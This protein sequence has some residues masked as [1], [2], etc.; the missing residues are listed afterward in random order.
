MS[1]APALLI[2]NGRVTQERFPRY[3][4]RLLPQ[5]VDYPTTVSEGYA[6]AIIEAYAQ[7]HG[8]ENEARIDGEAARSRAFDPYNPSILLHEER[9]ETRNLAG[10]LL[11]RRRV[12]SRGRGVGFL[13]RNTGDSNTRHI[14][15]S[16]PE[17]GLEKMFSEFRDDREMQFAQIFRPIIINRNHW[18]MCEI[19]L[20]RQ[21]NGRIKVN[22]H[23]YDPLYQAAVDVENDRMVVACANRVFV[24]GLFDL[25][26]RSIVHRSKKQNDGTS[27]A[28]VSC[29]YVGQRLAG[30]GLE[31]SIERDIGADEVPF[32][33]SA[34][35]LRLHQ[36]R[37][38]QQHPQRVLD[39]YLNDAA[40]H[41]FK[42]HTRPIDEAK[43]TEVDRRPVLSLDELGVQ[44]TSP[45]LYVGAGI[46]AEPKKGL[47][48]SSG[49]SGRTPA[50][51][52]P[53]IDR[54]MSFSYDES[55]RESDTAAFLRE[56]F[57]LENF[58]SALT[59]K[60]LGLLVGIIR[61]YLTEQQKCGFLEPSDAD[62]LERVAV[63]VVQFCN[64]VS[65]S[66]NDYI[67]A[68]IKSRDDFLRRQA[69]LVLALKAL[70][71]DKRYLGTPNLGSEL[72]KFEAEH[73]V[74]SMQCAQEN[75]QNLDHVFI[76]YEL[77]ERGSWIQ[78][79]WGY[80]QSFDQTKLTAMSSTSG[81]QEDESVE[82]GQT[83]ESR[84]MSLG[85]ELRENNDLYENWQSFHH[86][87]ETNLG[88][89]LAAKSTELETLPK[90]DR[91]LV[92]KN[93]Y[94]FI[95]AI[96]DENER[97]KREEERE[98]RA[99][100]KIRIAQEM[101][102]L[103]AIAAAKESS[104]GL[105]ALPFSAAT[106]QKDKGLYTKTNDSEFAQR[107]K[108]EPQ[109]PYTSVSS[110]YVVSATLY[111]AQKDEFEKTIWANNAE[112]GG[113]FRV[114]GVRLKDEEINILLGIALINAMKASDI[115]HA[116]AIEACNYAR[117]NGGIASVYD[118]KTNKYKRNDDSTINP[119]WKDFSAK[120]QKECKELGIFT[121][122]Q[123]PKNIVGM[124]LT[125]LPQSVLENFEQRS[126]LRFDTDEFA[127]LS[128][129]KEAASA[130]KIS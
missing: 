46:A 120:F 77:C 125:F 22:R 93:A 100:E 17:D 53:L 18:V 60:D 72:K 115:D 90:K 7:Q 10:N 57:Q 92:Y 59:E 16:S 80:I 69:N 55:L 13:Y 88:E 33:R 79:I 76:N 114:M 40:F 73:A 128:Q 82:E 86:T 20:T 94:D 113:K 68:T 110:S 21:S 118:T 9:S 19:H 4:E 8:F 3:L 25:E 50:V 26:S 48:V 66:S 39:I 12:G 49:P 81:S 130:I 54:V 71:E 124:R 30:E 117:I 78:F 112:R 111:Q 56:L 83:W 34:Q 122:R 1:A 84:F 121:G 96:V 5:D 95:Q 14:M 62:F 109:V 63:S 45:A 51:E 47:S 99:E 28:M 29:W 97:L 123:D 107:F 42:T 35:A 32:P 52:V 85:S 15:G 104:G 119:V 43:F 38:R 102:D 87:A 74:K 67:V 75:Y 108:S 58:V 27:C 116:V 61:S 24:G 126:D 98:R 65:S 31:D 36:M 106:V 41:I 64:K 44:A 11:R 103:S 91:E 2:H 129:V 101:A 127:L 23:Y 6:N 70:R 89:M 105:V 37:L